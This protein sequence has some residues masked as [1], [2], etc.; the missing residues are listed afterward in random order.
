MEPQKP[1]WSVQH[2]V[3][4]LTRLSADS[5]VA[6]AQRERA[7]RRAY[8]LHSQAPNSTTTGGHSE[9]PQYQSNKQC[10][11]H[12]WTRALIGCVVAQESNRD[13]GRN[14]CPHSTLGRQPW[15]LRDCQGDCP[16]QT[17]K[18][19]ERRFHIVLLSGNNT[20]VSTPLSQPNSI[21]VHKGS[22]T[23]LLL[24]NYSSRHARLG[25]PNTNCSRIFGCIRPYR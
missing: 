10:A 16:G 25:L 17:K 5:A 20:M 9:S 11:G 12:R 14:Q 18:R 23:V 22:L 21:R 15:D 8:H 13:G 2:G 24:C 19:S 7:K 1:L 3:G 6:D 4:L